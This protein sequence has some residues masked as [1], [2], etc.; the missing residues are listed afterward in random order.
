MYKILII[1][2]EF[3]PRWAPRIGYLVKYLKKDGYVVH[4]VSNVKGNRM[5]L[6]CLTGY[7]DSEHFVCNKKWRRYD[8]RNIYETFMP[9]RPSRG[10]I[11][12]DRKALELI[13]THRLNLILATTS[14]IWPAY[15]ACR[16]AKKCNLPI[17]IDFRDLAEQ[18]PKRSIFSR[19]LKYWP[20]H[21]RVQVVSHLQRIYR[22]NIL[23]SANA[24]TTVSTFHQDLLSREHR[25]C[26][27]IYNG[28]D[29]DWFYPVPPK[30]TRMFR[31]VYAGSVRNPA[32]RDSSYLLEAVSRLHREQR[33]DP[34]RF[35]CSFYCGDTGDNKIE[36]NVLQQ[37]I[38]E[39]FEF[40]EYIPADRIPKV[41]QEASILLLLTNRSDK[42]GPKGIMTTKLFEY[43]AVNRPILCV[44]SDENL[45][46]GAIN[47]MNAG[48][49]ARVAEQAYEFI[50]QQYLAWLA[51][52]YTVGNADMEK[53]QQ[54]SR[55][56]QAR[57]F[58][59]LINETIESRSNQNS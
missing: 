49:A 2:D 15:T 48:M 28:F 4:V 52:G 9:I 51:Q 37:G 19:P 33:I 50:M 31:I 8:P 38:A 45:I 22:S 1:A 57:Q 29:P 10:E 20:E 5:V 12:M 46:E 16:I 42:K 36:D 27:L 40:H 43:L 7:A 39:Y 32:L 59:T 23:K 13:K 24:A 44:R 18:Y 14:G 25:N 30:P 3:P 26:H 47:E 55:R 54:F 11:E 21:F 34:N 58:A 41:L 35:R 53:V 17:I 6:D 56:F